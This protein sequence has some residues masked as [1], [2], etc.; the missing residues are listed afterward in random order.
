VTSHFTLQST[1]DKDPQKMQAFV[2]ALWRATQWIKGHSPEEIYGAIEPY[3]GS[4]SRDANILD[5]GV[6]KKVTD[7][8]GVIDAASFA[9]GE[10]VWF[11]EMTG[12]KPLPMADVV[13][14]GFIEAARK[15]YPA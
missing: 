8:E 14:T 5:I 13:N 4:T 3:V 10:K 2:T 6:M 7:Y 12:I 9:R 15:A 1:I 11:R